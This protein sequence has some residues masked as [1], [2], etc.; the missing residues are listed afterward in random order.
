MIKKILS[1]SIL[2][3]GIS[4]SCPSFAEEQNGL[5]ALGILHDVN[6]TDEEKAFTLGFVT[7]EA[8]GF[9]MSNTICTKDPSGPNIGEVYKTVVDTLN[10]SSPEAL[11]AQKPADFIYQVLYAKYPCEDVKL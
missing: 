1:L 3:A 7:G 5:T 10:H 4:I 8:M 2:L 6:G 9:W 11:K